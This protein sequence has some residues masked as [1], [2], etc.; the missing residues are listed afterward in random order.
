MKLIILNTNDRDI[1]E[2]AMSAESDLFLM[3]EATLFC[4]SGRKDVP[5]FGDT[6]VLALKVD[7]E[8]RGLAERMVDGV[9]LID[10]DGMVD[11]LFSEYEVVNL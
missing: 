1:L 3:H 4:N 10:Y 5:E 11:L 7:L 8:K 6:K 2:K 9:E